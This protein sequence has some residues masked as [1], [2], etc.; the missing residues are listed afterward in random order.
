MGISTGL[1]KYTGQN[2]SHKRI[3]EKN[4]IEWKW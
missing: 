1:K 4:L 2:R 3:K